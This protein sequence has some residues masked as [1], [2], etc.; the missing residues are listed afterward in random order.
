MGKSHSA[1]TYISTESNFF[2]PGGIVYGVIN[3]NSAS[4]IPAGKLLI[5]LTGIQ[6]TKWLDT[7]PH[8]A[9]S[10]ILQ[11]FYPIWDFHG[12]L[13]KG[14][15]A[16]PFSFQLPANMLPSFSYKANDVLGSITYIL[17]A[18]IL[19]SSKIYQY[20]TIIWINS[21]QDQ[22]H[23]IHP[24]LEQRSFRI[25]SCCCSKPGVTQISVEIPEPAGLM[26]QEMNILVSVDNTQGKY[27]VKRLN[28][29]LVRFIRLKDSNASRG[30]N[31]TFPEIV[32]RAHQDVN[33]PSGGSE[34][35]ER[36]ISI[37]MGLMLILQDLWETPSLESSTVEC[38]YKVEVGL[39]FD[40]MLGAVDYK[41]SIP[42]KIY[43][44]MLSLNTQFTIP[45]LIS[46]EWNPMKLASDP[47]HAE[48]MFDDMN[49]VK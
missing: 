1:H 32:G 47:I 5:V 16:I 28:C 36:F 10:S 13:N 21:L 43:N 38:E 4:T 15:F 8:I 14:Q 25:Y 26:G 45:P 7:Y 20:Q 11:V 48:S 31:R 40:S 46:D 29:S 37:S 44:G 23:I 6:M 9:K 3:I 39:S 34:S 12:T 42:V 2:S 30:H 24:A 22:S 19:D 18:V 17:E 35:S 27:R 49:K 33:I 41:V